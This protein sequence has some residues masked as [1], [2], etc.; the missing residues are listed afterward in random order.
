M[1]VVLT[2]VV[3]V[4][5]QGLVFFGRSFLRQNDVLVMLVDAKTWR[6]GVNFRKEPFFRTN[7]FGF[8]A[9][10][11]DCFGLQTSV[12]KSRDISKLRT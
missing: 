9:N 7:P 5:C 12:L 8:Q 10:Q 2:T 11:E 1:T 4:I 6:S 3:M